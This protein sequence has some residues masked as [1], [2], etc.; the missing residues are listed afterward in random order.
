MEAQMIDSEAALT[1]TTGAPKTPTKR[2]NLSGDLAGS[3]TSAVVKTVPSN[4]I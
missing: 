1:A 2:Q 4:L 3:L